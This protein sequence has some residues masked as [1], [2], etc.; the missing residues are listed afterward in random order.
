ML[1]ILITYINLFIIS[2][3]YIVKFYTFQPPNPKGY[4]IKNSK[5]EIKE[6]IIDLKLN[7]GYIIEILMILNNNKKEIHNNLKEKNSNSQNKEIKIINNQKYKYNEVSTKGVNYELLYINNEDNKT[8]IPLFLFKPIKTN[9]NSGDIKNYLIIYCHGNCGDIGTTFHNCYL[10]SKNLS[11]NVL[12]FEYPGYGLSNDINNINEK[13]TY[14]N[15]RQTYKYARKELKYTSNNIIIFGYSLGTGIAFDLACDKDYPIGGVILQSAFL[16]IVRTIYN[17]KK[18][19]YF[20]LFNNCD[21]AKLCNSKIYFIHGD[22]DTIVP[23]VHGRILSLLIPKEFFCG[24]FTVHGA[25]HHNILKIAENKFYENINNFLESLKENKK[26]NQEQNC[27][28]SNIT[29]IK[30]FDMTDFTNEFQNKYKKKI[31]FEDNDNITSK[32]KLNIE[33]YKENISV[34]FKKDFINNSKE[35]IKNIEKCNHEEDITNRNTKNI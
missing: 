10:I 25:D 28:D 1:D 34:H 15:I 16:S 8:I 5:N 6:N 13:R 17:F 11:C 27:S 29:I 24:F 19:Y 4:R 12:S 9:D 2:L 18:T 32:E 31:K 21:K 33:N 22:K 23:Y 14:F 7:E 30:N 3:K 35:K 20:D 26:N